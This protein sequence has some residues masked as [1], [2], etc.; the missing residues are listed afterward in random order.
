MVDT[1][2][3]GQLERDDCLPRQV[4]I[5]S[6]GAWRISPCEW[7]VATGIE[8]APAMRRLIA[9]ARHSIDVMTIALACPMRTP[10]MGS[11]VVRGRVIPHWVAATLFA[12]KPAIENLDAMS[13][14]G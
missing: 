13:A 14:E 2:C 12:V 6:P 7:G 3:I 4:I 8:G 9:G 1:T 11:G 10:T 5:Q